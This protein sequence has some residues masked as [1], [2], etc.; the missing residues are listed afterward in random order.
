MD[1]KFSV[2]H[3]FSKE[4]GEVYLKHIQE[5]TFFTDV[6]LACSDGKQIEAHRVILSSQS[7]FFNRILTSNTKRQLLVYI[8]NISYSELQQ[9]L[10]FL[11]Q[12]Q[13]EVN[14]HDLEKFLSLGKELEVVGLSDLTET[15]E[16]D[17]KSHMV[18]SQKKDN[19]KY[20]CDQ[21]EYESVFRRAIKR[22]QDAIHIGIKH[23]CNE[24][25]KEYTD[26]Y[27]LKN[28]KKS[29]H[30]GLYFQCDQCNKTFSRQKLL[31]RHEREH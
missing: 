17:E 21:C 29:V 14:E 22:H 8:P 24:C 2:S 9:I 18:L 12:G 13:L 10:K 6:T 25:P 19:G 26:V 1:S 4:L 31:L 7:R 11:Y 5:D 23:A 20:A 15:E 16:K 28:H 27:D 30:Q 3:N